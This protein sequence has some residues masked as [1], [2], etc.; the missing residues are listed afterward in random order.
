MDDLVLY[1]DGDLDH[2]QNLMGSKLNQDLCYDF[3]FP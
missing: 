3:C 2:S 1:P